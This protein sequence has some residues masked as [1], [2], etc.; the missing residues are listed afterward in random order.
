MSVYGNSGAPSQNTLNYDAVLSTSLFNYQ[1][2][3]TDNISKSNTIFYMIQ[4]EGIYE[5]LDGGYSIQMPLMYALGS[6]DWFDS[7]DVLNTDP[8]DGVT[9]AF[10][11]WRQLAVPISI[12]RKEERQNSSRERIVDLL[13]TKVMQGELGIKEKFSRAMLQGSL[14][15]GGTSLTANDSSNVNGSLGIEPIFNLISATPASNSLIGNINPSTATWWQN[16]STQSALTTSN[17]ASDFF[18]E[19]DKVYNNASR[20]PGGPPNII[21]SDQVT[22]QIARAAYGQWARNND[23]KEDVNYPFEN[24]KFNRAIWCWDEFMPDLQNS[25]LTPNT[26]AGTCLML[27]TKYFAVK[28]DTETNFV[29]TPFVRP[30]NQDARV[31]HILWMGNLCINNRRK[32]AV[33]YNIPRSLTWTI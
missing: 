5:P 30:A 15:S 24:F 4:K 28:Y 6:A 7:Y 21:V 33:W 29:S 25:T 11:D 1:R 18:F 3:L 12:S 2:T 19:A 23:V 26:G 8:T 13:K 17:K 9:S 10:F 31:A 16:F 14:A 32:H 27:N 22:Y 20:G